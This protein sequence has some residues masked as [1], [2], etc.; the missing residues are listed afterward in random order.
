MKKGDI[1]GDVATVDL[2]ELVAKIR[3]V[4][5]AEES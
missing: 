1:V 3:P 2:A 4:V 5:P